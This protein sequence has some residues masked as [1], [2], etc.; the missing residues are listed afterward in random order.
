MK[1]HCISKNRRCPVME[2]MVYNPNGRY[3]S[4]IPGTVPAV[5]FWNGA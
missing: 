2:R 1:N 4:L 5:S 3:S